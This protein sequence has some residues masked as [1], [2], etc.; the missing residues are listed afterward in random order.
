MV[1]GVAANVHE[2]KRELVKK[3]TKPINAVI[4]VPSKCKA[5]IIGSGGRTIREISDAYEVKINV[6]KEVNEN[7]YDEDMDDTTSNVSLFGDFESVNLAKAKILAIVKEETKNATI[8]LVV[9]DENTYHTLMF[10][11]LPPMRVMKRSKS[12]SIKNRVIL[13]YRVLVNKQ[14]PRRHLFKII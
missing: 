7:S 11:S 5:S 3:L 10:P 9:E 12:N 13:S 2:A 4:E 6:S 1:S 8:K 14:K